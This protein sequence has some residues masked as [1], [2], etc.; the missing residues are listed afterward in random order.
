[1]VDFVSTLGVVADFVYDIFNLQFL[2]LG[3]YGGLVFMFF[4]LTLVGW[5]LQSLWGGDD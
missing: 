5:V 2:H 4:L 1:M 3:T